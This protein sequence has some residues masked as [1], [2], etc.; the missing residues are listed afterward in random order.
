MVSIMSERH[1]NAFTIGWDYLGLY[2]IDKTY[3]K[4]RNNHMTI[5]LDTYGFL[6]KYKR[7][8]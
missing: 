3:S 8:M 5:C 7:A 2:T 4:K 1:D 6:M